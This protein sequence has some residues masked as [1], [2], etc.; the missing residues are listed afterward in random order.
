MFTESPY[1]T[2]GLLAIGSALLAATLGALYMY[3]YGAPLF[4]DRTE[5]AG[6]IHPTKNGYD[7]RESI[8]TVGPFEGG[9]WLL[10]A[11]YEITNPS[12]K[13]NVMIGQTIIRHEKGDNRGVRILPAT[14]KNVDRNR[15][16]EDWAGSVVDCPPPGKW[17]YSLSVYA[18]LN[19]DTNLAIVVERGY[20]LLQAW[21][22]W[23]WRD[24]KNE[25]N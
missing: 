11:Q 17:Y 14:T 18:G 16:H 1:K 20:G 23:Q 4:E 3:S 8:Y 6:Y 22:L 12:D 21:R 13:Y 5:N 19:K 25:L 2:F 9:C 24:T 7:S 10:T 15:H